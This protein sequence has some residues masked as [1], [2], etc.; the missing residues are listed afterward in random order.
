MCVLCM[1]GVYLLCV[2]V[3]CVC[4]C[5]C[6]AGGTTEKDPACFSSLLILLPWHPAMTRVHF[7]WSSL[8]CSSGGAG[9]MLPEVGVTGR[10]TNQRLCYEL[11]EGRLS[12]CALNTPSKHTHTRSH[13]LRYAC[14]HTHMCTHTLYAHTQTHTRACTKPT[15]T[16]VHTHIVCTHTQTQTHTRACTKPTHTENTRGS[17]PFSAT[18]SALPRPSHVVSLCSKCYVI[19]N[20]YCS[21]AL[22]YRP[23]VYH[24]NI[25]YLVSYVQFQAMF[26]TV[27]V[28][29]YF[30][31]DEFVVL[32][33][34][35]QKKGYG[36]DHQNLRLHRCTNKVFCDV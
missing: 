28:K 29:N 23:A 9:Q 20:S 16:H 35:P 27:K 15:H 2:D 32:C 36:N 8:H 5:I 11:Q 4:V 22:H 31:C 1:H 12:S 7:S 19:I 18:S 25:C 6:F 13:S 26:H 21:T 30:L 10:E 14:P 34:N 17:K 3:C 33:E 24:G